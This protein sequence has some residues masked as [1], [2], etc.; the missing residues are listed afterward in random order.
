MEKLLGV[1]LKDFNM[2]DSS[3]VK[4]KF[5]T[6]NFVYNPFAVSVSVNERKKKRTP[7]GF[8]TS[9]SNVGHKKKSDFAFS[10]NI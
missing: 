8:T 5:C 6:V 2:Q 1:H 4:K 3:F 7:Y 10:Q 9:E